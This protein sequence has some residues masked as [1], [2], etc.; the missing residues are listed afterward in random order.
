ML[1]LLHPEPA[2][3][4]PDAHVDDCADIPLSR[5]DISESDIQAVVNVL[6]TPSLSLGPK[7]PEFEAAFAE[8]IGARYA[9]ATSSGTAALH[10]TVR[11]LG[12]GP[13]DEVITSPFSFVASANCM[14]FERAAPVFVDIDPES[15]NL[16]PNLIER[17]ITART[18]GHSAGSRVRTPGPDGRHP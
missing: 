8:Y 10:L 15:F 3:V 18:K 16:D 5:P 13:G 4:G 1:P 6:R 12:I 14:L 9:T 17:K 7:L 11:A 2:E